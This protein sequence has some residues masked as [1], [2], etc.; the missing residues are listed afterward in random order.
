MY[1]YSDLINPDIFLNI[2]SPW[3]SPS[4]IEDLIRLSEQKIKIRIITFDDASNLQ[5]QKSIALLKQVQNDYLKCR[6]TKIQ[7][8]SKY[9]IKDNDLLIDGTANLTKT[10]L[11]IIK[12][13]ITVIRD[14]G[15]IM[16]NQKIF[17]TDWNDY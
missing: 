7:N 12:N 4:I 15:Q 2:C 3:I 8:H 9:F 17:E 13:K 10:S 16:K 1:F 5:Q 14:K 11:Y 6:I